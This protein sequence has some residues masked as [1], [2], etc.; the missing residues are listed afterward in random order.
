MRTAGSRDHQLIVRI[1]VVARVGERRDR[2]RGSDGRTHLDVHRGRSADDRA[3]HHHARI[4]LEA[5][6]ECDVVGDV[7]QVRRVVVRVAQLLV[8]RRVHLLG[9]GAADIARDA[10]VR[11][12]ERLQRPDLAVVRVDE[13][14][15]LERAIILVADHDDREVRIRTQKAGIRGIVVERALDSLERLLEAAPVD[16]DRRE[17]I[18]RIDQRAAVVRR[19][20]AVRVLDVRNE[21]CRS[22]RC[23]RWSGGCRSCHDPSSSRGGRR[24]CWVL[25]WDLRPRSYPD[26]R[27]RRRCARSESRRSRSA[28]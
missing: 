28:R 5:L 24:R 18:E 26:P 8:A 13:A 25:D 3:D 11:A 27:S 2:R 22:P 7:R 19:A 1:G 21:R 23:S 6:E 12:P 4:G 15:V 20:R 16:T 9:R 14:R 10:V 17:S